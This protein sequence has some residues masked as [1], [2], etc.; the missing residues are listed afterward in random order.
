M[1]P[2]PGDPE[3]FRGDPFRGDPHRGQGRPRNIPNATNWDYRLRFPDDRHFAQGSPPE[4]HVHNNQYQDNLDYSRPAA[5]S[6]PYMPRP[7]Y[8]RDRSRPR[9][10]T[11]T[12]EEAIIAEY[13]RR[14]EREVEE[15]RLAIER[16]QLEV[17]LKKKAAKAADEAAVA[18]WHKEQKDRED[19]EKAAEL[20]LELKREEEKLKKKIAD[21]EYM[22]RMRR[23]LARFGLRENQVRAIVEHKKHGENLMVLPNNE[24]A[25]LAPPAITRQPVYPKLKR[26]DVSKESLI[27][28]DLPWE[29]TSDSHEYII[30]LRE[31][32]ERE[33][34][35]LFEHTRRLRSRTLLAVEPARGR[36]GQSQW[37]R[38]RSRSKNGR[39]RSRGKS[40][41]QIR[42]AEAVLKRL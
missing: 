22:E 14:R 38:R 31:M 28:Y 15:Q 41:G 5:G 30:I 40:P 42:L 12:E 23:D 9:S 35:I 36:E 10:Y 18:K 26:K 24:T 25:M 32:S 27:Y 37:V 20:R 3:D 16:F 1:P 19:E 33:T 21:A 6:P 8:D 34:D 13:Q 11:R 29:Y 2:Y 7:T 39:S 17:E 4:I